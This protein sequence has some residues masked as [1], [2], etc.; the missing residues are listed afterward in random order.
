MINIGKTGNIDDIEF[1]RAGPWNSRS[2][3]LIKHCGNLAT[4]KYVEL[5]VPVKSYKSVRQVLYQLQ[6]RKKLSPNYGIR[7]TDENKVV[8]IHFKNSPAIEKKIV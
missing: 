6:R 1:K 2:P 7:L 5:D 4:G 8:L 3:D